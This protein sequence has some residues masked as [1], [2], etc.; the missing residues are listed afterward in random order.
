M[1]NTDINKTTIVP[2]ADQEILEEY[3][4]DPRTQ[5]FYP[6]TKS[7]ELFRQ[8]KA[9]QTR[10]AVAAG[11]TGLVAEGLQFG[12]GLGA[13]KDV[14]PLQEEKALIKA[15]MAEDAEELTEEQ[16]ALYRDAASAKLDRTIEEG[17]RR[18]EAI[19][20]STGQLDVKTLLTAAQ[21]GLRQKAAQGTQIEADL[22]KVDVAKEKA[23]ADQDLR[24]QARLDAINNTI[25]DAK[26]KAIRQPLH[27]LIGTMAETV[28][29]IFAHSPGKTIESQTDRLLKKGLTEEEVSELIKTSKNNPKQARKDLRDALRAKRRPAPVDD[30]SQPVTEQATEEIQPVEAMEWSDASTE[31]KYA[32]VL[33][34]LQEDGSIRYISP[35]SGNEVI[36]DPNN[37]KLAAAY[38]SIMKDRP[39]PQVPLTRNQIAQR[40]KDIVGPS[41]GQAP[42]PTAAQPQSNVV[43]QDVQNQSNI[44][45]QD[46]Q[47]RAVAADEAAQA[48]ARAVDEEAQKRTPEGDPRGVEFANENL[49]KVATLYQLQDTYR[50]PQTGRDD[51]L[52]QKGNESYV[53]KFSD[54]KWVVYQN[55]RLAK[56]NSPMKKKDGK[57]IEFTLQEA[58]DHRSI[59]VRD[60]YDLARQG[61]FA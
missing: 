7:S 41:Q 2:K 59:N 25:I 58:R 51:P 14:E 6:G 36:V 45:D 47:A 10:Q 53:Y 56:L 24:D 57:A 5:K 50:D 52:Y 15:R 54:G 27:R 32:G 23:K 8:Q 17:R 11:A 55:M 49:E 13:L 40:A 16:K 20:A 46:A 42:E 9:A 12:I 61:G 60:L 19:A 22:A 37:P 26:N 1:A 31:G 48:K 3:V 29:L 28:G 30:G 18:A 35:Y 39:E 4:Y 21:S 34:T 33:Y 43:E 38:E 44:A